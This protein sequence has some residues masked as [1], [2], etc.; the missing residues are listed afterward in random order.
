MTDIRDVCRRYGI[1]SRTL[2]FY[3]EKGL[4]T[5][6]KDPYSG[7]RQYSEKQLAD[8]RNVLALR[9][10]G[11]PIK[12]IREYLQRG[13]TLETVIREQEAQ[14]RSAIYAKDREIRILHAALA[15][16][17]DGKDLLSPTWD[18]LEA[19]LDDH[20]LDYEK[21]ARLC[22]Q[23]VVEKDLDRLYAY[24]GKDM[25]PYLSSFEEARES[26]MHG[27]GAF[28]GYGITERD[29]TFPN[30]IYQ[31]LTFENAVIRIKFVFYGEK[32]HGIWFQNASKGGSHEKTVDQ[33]S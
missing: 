25:M 26:L 29:T 11:L 21:T 27:Y 7:R 22:G 17:E 20:L 8:L 30:I 16:L 19:F 14:L 9:A 23:Y 6:Q 28:Q 10:I 18:H 15:A 3:E 12:A 33:N 5:S 31:Y 13:A 24:F 2:R 4:I 1:T 32:I